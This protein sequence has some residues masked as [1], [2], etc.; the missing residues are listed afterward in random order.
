VSEEDPIGDII[1]DRLA[2][3]TLPIAVP[4]TGPPG[5]A[6]LYN[7]LLDSADGV[8]QVIELLLTADVLAEHEILEFGVRPDM[9][10][11]VGAAVPNLLVTDVARSWTHDAAGFAFVPS[12]FMHAHGRRKG[13]RWTT[14][15][16]TDGFAAQPEDLADVG[17]DQRRGFLLGHLA[18][19]SRRPLALLSS[20]VRRDSAGVIHWVGPVPEGMVGSPVFTIRRLDALSFKVVCLGVLLSG[21]EDNPV[22]TFDAIRQA[23]D[24]TLPAR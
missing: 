20:S 10:E 14:Q 4:V 11:P 1:A 16:V 6:F 12:A 19:G 8:D 21:T 23:V 3:A 13:W 2:R 5:T 9:T 15:E 22:A 17:A 7:H 18:D 24:L